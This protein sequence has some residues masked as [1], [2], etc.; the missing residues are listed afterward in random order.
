[1]LL[2]WRGFFE[3]FLVFDSKASSCGFVKVSSRTTS[4]VDGGDTSIVI[5]LW[6]LR[7]TD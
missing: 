5:V 7:S 1:L 2:H 3:W 6:R 4:M